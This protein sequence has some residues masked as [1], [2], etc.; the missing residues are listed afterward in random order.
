MDMVMVN[1]QA[2]QDLSNTI[3]AYLK[4]DTNNPNLYIKNECSDKCQT[5]AHKLTE[6][7]DDISKPAQ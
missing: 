4:L 3:L 1:K 6:F 7:L 5:F 2:K